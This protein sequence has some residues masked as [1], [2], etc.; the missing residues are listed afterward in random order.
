MKRLFLLAAAALGGSFCFI[1]TASAHPVDTEG[2]TPTRSY[3]VPASDPAPRVTAK[4]VR[5]PQPL[6]RVTVVSGDTLSDLGTR[7]HRTWE[8]LAS[9]NHIPNPNLIYVGQVLTVPLVTYVAGPVALPVPAPSYAPAYVSPPSVP[10]HYSAP[11]RTYTPPAPRPVVSY[12]GGGG[13]GGGTWACIAQ[14]ESGGN[15]A[16]NTGNGYYGAF[17]DTIGSW[18]AAGGGPGLPSN[19]SYSQQLA[20][21]QRIQ[22]QQGWG[23]WPNTSRMCGM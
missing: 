5:V 19:Y 20:V 22:A 2:N 18:Q 3:V 14:H 8:Q 12:S 6:P 17:Q 9:Y 13:E 1:S 10:V 16:T 7:T 15:P 21:N 11:T 23:A 4:A